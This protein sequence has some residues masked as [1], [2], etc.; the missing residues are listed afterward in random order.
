MAVEAANASPRRLGGIPHVAA[1]RPAARPQGDRYV[2]APKPTTEEGPKS[3]VGKVADT[4]WAGT[5]G[6]GAGGLGYFL[7]KTMMNFVKDMG[8]LTLKNVV[9]GQLVGGVIAGLPFT[10]IG[11]S[12]GYKKGEVSAQRY[13]GN[14]ISG[15]MSFGL[16]GVGAVAATAL[17]PVGG[18]LGVAVGLAAGGLVSSVFDKTLGR[19]ISDTVAQ[20]LPKEGARKAADFV[21]K[22]MTNPIDKA[23]VQPVKR[24]WKVFLATGG[25]AALYFGIR[26]NRP[27]TTIELVKKGTKDALKYVVDGKTYWIKA[28]TVAGNGGKT[29]LKGLGAMGVSSIPQMIGD[30]FL[31]S[32]MPMKP[33]KGVDLEPGEGKIFNPEDGH[34]VDKPADEETK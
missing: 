7:S 23:F 14:V 6:V 24:H 12:F 3:T 21:V 33:I 10:L 5:L 1:D 22:Y 25:A 4:A 34:I 18:F 20:A 11:D 8:P 30:G 31:A 28:T 15:A 17:L 13:W 27:Q 16:W 29:A 32:K 9:K 26:G 19:E 2:A